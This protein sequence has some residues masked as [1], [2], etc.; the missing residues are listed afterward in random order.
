MC[1]RWGTFCISPFFGCYNRSLC[2]MV[3]AS[4]VGILVG[5]SVRV[6]RCGVSD[7]LCCFSTAND[8]IG[9]YP[10]CGDPA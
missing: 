1:G 4:V 7:R 3:L 8:V 6:E 10:E 5:R 2:T 9:G